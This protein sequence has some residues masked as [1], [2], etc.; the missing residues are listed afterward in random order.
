MTLKERITYALV[1]YS[2]EFSPLPFGKTS[3][4]TERNAEIGAQAFDGNRAVIAQAPGLWHPFPV[5]ENLRIA[6]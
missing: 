3:E 4:E 1:A 2:R 6:A 5:K